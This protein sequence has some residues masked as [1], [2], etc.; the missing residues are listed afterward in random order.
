[1]LKDKK[2]LS[3]SKLK[4]AVFKTVSDE[5]ENKEK[6]FKNKFDT[7]LFSLI[8]KG[9]VIENNDVYSLPEKSEDETINNSNETYKKRKKNDTDDSINKKSN[10]ASNESN[11]SDQQSLAYPD[12]WKNGEKYWRDGT[13]D[14]NYLQNNPDRYIKHT[15]MRSFT[16][17]NKELLG[18]FVVT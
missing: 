10:V 3:A 12:L 1:M 7:D 13:L 2:E 8:S 17:E 4:K 16:I 18:Y 6:E 11:K 5:Y 14:D 9:K 15:D